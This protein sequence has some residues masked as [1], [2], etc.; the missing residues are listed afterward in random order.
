MALWTAPGDVVFD[1]FNGIGS[2]GHVA[3]TMGR[4]YIGSELKDSYYRQSIRNLES[5]SKAAA[6]ESRD[7]FAEVEASEAA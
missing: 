1:P 3:L 4:K 7:L 2:T 6:N 5:A